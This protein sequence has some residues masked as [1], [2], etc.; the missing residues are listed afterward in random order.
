MKLLMTKTN[1]NELLL[2]QKLAEISGT[3]ARDWFIV[4]RARH[5]MEHVFRQ[6][7]KTRGKGD[8][9]T[10]PFTC[11]TAVNPIIAAGFMP[12]YCDISRQT[13][14][15][16]ATKLA[17]VLDSRTRAVVV[18]HSFGIPADMAEINKIIVSSGKPLIMEDSAHCLGFIGELNG[19]PFADVSVHS[20]GAEKILKTSFGGALWIN[21]AMEDRQLYAALVASLNE[22]PGTSAIV[23]ARVWL[24]PKMNGALNRLPKA[25]S[26]NCRKLL[27]KTTMFR[28]PIMP[29]EQKT[30]NY[31]KC[32]KPTAGQIQLILKALESYDKN[33]THRT[34]ITKLYSDIFEDNPVAAEI[35]EAVRS[36]KLACVRFPLL[37]KSSVQAEHIFDTL[38]ASGYS[39]GRW[40]RP[41][42]FPGV[43]QQE[44]YAYEPG[45]C[46]V[47]E[48]VSS[49]IINLPTTSRIT[50][51]TAKEIAH[52]VISITNK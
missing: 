31:E 26:H 15:I 21:P 40:Y 38:V 35:P 43:K 10:Q 33:I 44:A 49:K 48:D 25:L 46:P 11:V 14:S 27:L 28:S 1:H 19:K 20:F 34:E 16:D 13:F 52:A 42:F 9:I 32:Q 4:S 5:G 23:N 8:V 3:E 12:V 41:L 29:E 47:A 17:E 37:A 51:Q 50:L 24:Y 7:G 36:N 18:Q 22:L 45:L 6:L 2:K 30:V 39:A